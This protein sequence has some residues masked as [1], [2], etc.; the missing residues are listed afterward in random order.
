M[1]PKSLVLGLTLSVWKQS[2]AKLR[3]TTE[4]TCHQTARPGQSVDNRFDRQPTAI[5]LL[6]LN[7]VISKSLWEEWP[8]SS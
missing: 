6:T 1:P 5:L 7:T 8:D 2:A 4:R 3:E